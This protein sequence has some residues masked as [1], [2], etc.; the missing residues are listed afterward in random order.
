YDLADHVAPQ[1]VWYGPLLAMYTVAAHCAFVPRI[2]IAAVTLAGGA[3]TVGSSDTLVRGTVLGV[4]AY[5]L[6][7]ASAASR[8]H[9]AELEEKAQRLE[10]ARRLEA[11]RA[12]ER[13]RA[14][15]ARD[16]HDILAHAVALMVVQAEAGPVV[17]RTDPGR[18]ERA[19][20]A[21]AET[22]RDAMVQ[23]RR[24]LGVLKEEQGHGELEP[25][26]TL[27]G[28]DTLVGQVPGVT[29]TLTRA[30]GPG[31]L[32]PDGEVAAYRIVQ[33]ALTNVVKHSGATRAEVR[34]EWENENLMLSVT[35]NGTGAGSAPPSGGHG[36]IGIRE[37]AAACGGS[38]TAGPRGDGHPGFEVLVRLPLNRPSTRL[39]TV[40][41]S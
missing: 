17:V 9:A 29:A 10:H 1:P 16:M 6:G 31:G 11:E 36:L 23:L 3:L 35:D 2:V 4:A 22:G 40:A 41:R 7:R 12:A 19:F 28:L 37:R 25:Q 26:P 34:L 30:G 38:A 15:I 21:I 27:D 20:D 8:A 32:T 18:A 14:R 5:A 39:S 24:L 13:E 33:E